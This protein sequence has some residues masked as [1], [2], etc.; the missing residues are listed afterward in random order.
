M[1][2]PIGRKMNKAQYYHIQETNS[3]DYCLAFRY[4]IRTGAGLLNYHLMIQ[5]RE[6][7]FILWFFQAL[8][9]LFLLS[10]VFAISKRRTFLST[11]A[12]GDMARICHFQM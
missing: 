12:I 7:I 3:M 9:N 4:I 8:G 6:F 10:I 2:A 1:V 5:T 11:M